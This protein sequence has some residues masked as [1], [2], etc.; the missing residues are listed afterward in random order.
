[1]GVH[2]SMILTSVF[3]F[4]VHILCTFVFI[5]CFF[6]LGQRTFRFQTGFSPRKVSQMT[7]HDEALPN[8]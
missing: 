4:W 2:F 5:V 3:L 1:M 8:V 7:Y 6:N